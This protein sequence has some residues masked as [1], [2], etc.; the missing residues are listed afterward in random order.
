[1]SAQYDETDILCL[2]LYRSVF[3]KIPT[4][5]TLSKHHLAIDCAL[6]ISVFVVASCGLAYELI[7]GGAGELFVPYITPAEAGCNKPKRIAPH[8]MKSTLTLRPITN[9]RPQAFIR[10]DFQ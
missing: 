3:A 10:K 4:E 1:M 2:T 7:A 8:N 5:P 9:Q 6:I